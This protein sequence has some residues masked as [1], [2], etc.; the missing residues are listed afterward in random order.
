MKHRSVNKNFI[1][2]LFLF[3]LIITIVFSN[4]D[5][6]DNTKEIE[7]LKEFKEWLVN[8]N[9]Y[10]NPNIDIELLDKY[11][12][13]IVAKKSIKKQDKL[14]SI[15]KDIIMSNIGGYPKKIPKEIY[16]QVQSI[17]LSPTNLQAVFIMYS[18]LNEKS[19]WHPYVT[20]LPES[21]STSLYFSDNELD[22]L[23][24]SQLKEFTIIRKDGIER[25]YESTFSRLSKLVPEFS[26]LAL[27]NQELFT[28]ALS[29]VW[30]R[31]FSL[32]E[33]DGGMVPLADMFN[34]EDR[35]KSKVL[36]K[37]TDTTLDYYASDDIAE[38]EQIFTPYGVYKPLSSSQMLMD[39]GFIFDEGTVS[40]NVAITVPVFH[41]DE[42]NLSTKQE[43]LEEN[44]IINEVFLLQK[45]DPLPADLLLYARVKNLIAKECDQ[46]KKH[47]LS[48]NTRNTPLNTRNEKVSLRFLENLIHR[49]LDSYGTNLESDKNLLKN[50]YSSDNNNNNNNDNNSVDNNQI[51]FNV[52]N[53]IKIRI[54]EKE[55]LISALNII[56]KARSELINN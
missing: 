20:V 33:N 15:P 36:P 10:I 54:M 23:Q 17:G 40:D 53:A 32:A 52:I 18:K 30:S 28:W 27:Y 9:A 21:F 39:Y 1:R 7:S 8:N 46:A 49:Y 29:C 13:S 4:G 56:E 22:E 51:S 50:Y 47:F 19:F 5:V 3:L 48:P 45:T 11:G 25:H 42:P 2:I 35:S 38:G 34:A 14:I 41:N 44:D 31:A 43:I 24:A 55:I 12:R 37:V 6:K 26:N 16:E